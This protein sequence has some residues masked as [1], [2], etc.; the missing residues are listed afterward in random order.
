MKKIV[1]LAC[2]FLVILTSCENKER[3]N[4]IKASLKNERTSEANA[5]QNKVSFSTPEQNIKEKEEEYD[6][7]SSDYSDEYSEDNYDGSDYSEDEYEY[8]PEY[9]NEYESEY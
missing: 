4:E 2:L 5:S 6:D 3:L 8:E 7:E 9:E 1:F